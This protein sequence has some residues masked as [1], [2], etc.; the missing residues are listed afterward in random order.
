MY[1]QGDRKIKQRSALAGQLSSIV[2][3]LTSQYCHLA[4]NF[5]AQ[6]FDFTT[7][8]DICNGPLSLSEP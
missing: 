3:D 2:S 4:A 5:A 6:E 7:I 1:K 8:D